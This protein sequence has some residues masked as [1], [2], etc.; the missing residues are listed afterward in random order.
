[1]SEGRFANGDNGSRIRPGRRQAN[2]CVIMTG[3]ARNCDGFHS[4]DRSDPVTA[5]RPEPRKFEPRVPAREWPDNASSGLGLF[6]VAPPQEDRGMNPTQT[7]SRN[8]AALPPWVTGPPPGGGPVTHG[9]TQ[10][11]PPNPVPGRGA[12]VSNFQSAE[13]RRFQS[14]LTLP[15]DTNTGKVS[16]G[17]DR[18]TDEFT[19]DRARSARAPPCAGIA[20]DSG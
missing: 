16:D 14:E 10:H 4:G 12:K 19:P 1:M 2:D 15:V 3:R 17:I 18:E 9:S 11:H 5:A 6:P 20:A 7:G 13:V 8:D